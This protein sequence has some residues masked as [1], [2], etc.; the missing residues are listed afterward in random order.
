MFQKGEREAS[1]LQDRWE[2]SHH[3]HICN[4]TEGVRRAAALLPAGTVLAVGSSTALAAEAEAKQS[5]G[6]GANQERT[7][8]QCHAGGFA[9]YAQGQQAARSCCRRER[10]AQEAS[11]ETVWRGLCTVAVGLIALDMA[12]VTGADI[13]E[14]AGFSR[15]DAMATDEVWQGPARCNLCEP[16]VRALTGRAEPY[17]QRVLR[18]SPWAVI[19]PSHDI[20][21]EEDWP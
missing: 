5:P 7:G 1:F 2:R 21:A 18:A 14:T 17:V 6:A 13:Q 16:L 15:Q 20:L 11:G 9:R 8:T 12:Q 10:G 19:R 4:T 3:L